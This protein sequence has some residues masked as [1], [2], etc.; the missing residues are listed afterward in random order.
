VRLDSVRLRIEISSKEKF[1]V[2][3]NGACHTRSMTT[4]MP[5]PTPMHIV[6]SA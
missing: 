5:C 1:C 2:V 4:A 6:H 3:A